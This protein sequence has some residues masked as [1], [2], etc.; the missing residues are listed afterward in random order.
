MVSQAAARRVELAGDSTGWLAK[1]LRLPN[2]TLVLG[3]ALL[4][5]ALLA[6]LV[7]LPPPPGNLEVAP[8]SQ[9]TL[10]IPAFFIVMLGFYVASVPIAVR[11]ALRSVRTLAG[12]DEHT[13]EVFARELVHLPRR[14]L[15]GGVAC[16]CV[17]HVGILIGVGVSWDDYSRTDL[18]A[19]RIGFS[20]VMGWVHAAAMGM[21]TAVLL[22]Q[23]LLFLRIGREVR[24][25][26]L[27]DHAALAPFVHTSLRPTLLN[28][29]WIACATSFHIDWGGS[30]AVAPQII[31][32]LPML[33]LMNGMMFALPLRGIHQRLLAERNAELSRVNA[34]I[35]GDRQALRDSLV[36][37]DAATLNAV[38]LLAYRDHVR[39]F[40]TWPFD[41]SAL[42]RLGL[43]LGIPLL[44][45][46]G[47]AIVERGIDVLLD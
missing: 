37:A 27:L 39:S 41:A 44:G 10:R 31:W 23:G 13:L 40:S 36:A 5:G 19:T 16:G 43:Y 46:V 38:D 28:T 29:L 30:L 9:L 35:R 25:V 17:A 1:S 33:F 15:W 6:L 14:W 18:L 32:L 11:S 2:A 12:L 7:L 8:A 21:A 34:A 4:S 20:T 24:T 26:D 3:G 45:W 42:L 22:R 47:G